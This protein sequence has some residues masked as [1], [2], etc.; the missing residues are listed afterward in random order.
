MA[1]YQAGSS[2][3]QSVDQ[4]H[5]Q[6]VYDYSQYYQQQQPAEPQSADLLQD[7]GQATSPGVVEDEAHLVQQQQQAAAPSFLL[8]DDPQP[9]AKDFTTVME[10]S[11]SNVSPSSPAAGVT[12]EHKAIP[13][14]PQLEQRPSAVASAQPKNMMVGSKPGKGPLVPME[15]AAKWD[16]Y[17][18][19][20][21]LQ[22]GHV[23]Q[24]GIF[25]VRDCAKW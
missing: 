14:L 15:V 7:Q 1:Y 22:T 2:E 3:P 24:A 16:V 4:D 21:L 5:Q 13:Q 19:E 18:Q 23:F 11:S 20:H 17:L 9:E 12:V 10:S 8:R 6:A 25:D